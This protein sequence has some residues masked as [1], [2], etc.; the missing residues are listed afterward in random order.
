MDTII[1]NEVNKYK[2]GLQSLETTVGNLPNVAPD[3]MERLAS[4]KEK[5]KKETQTTKEVE[6]GTDNGSSD[7][8]GV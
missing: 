2:E 4:E 1:T 6:D 5:A 3:E 8:T 7:Q